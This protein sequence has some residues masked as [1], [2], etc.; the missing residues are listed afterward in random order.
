MSACKNYLLNRLYDLSK[1]RAKSKAK[2]EVR[3]WTKN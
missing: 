1:S 2:E 3:E